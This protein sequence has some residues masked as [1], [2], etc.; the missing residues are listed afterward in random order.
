MKIAILIEGKTERAFLPFLRSFLER[1]L[2]GR[3]P[4][5]DPVPY[6]GRIPKSDKLKREVKR[7]LND[8]R[9]PADAVVALTDVYTRTQP[10]EFEDAEDAKRKMRE[11]VGEENRFY[12]HAAQFEFEAWLLPYW[13]VLQRLAGHNASAPG[14]DPERINH[15]NPPSKRIGD[16]FRRGS[17]GRAYVKEMEAIRVLREA[18]PSI[19]IAQC[20]ELKALVNTILALCGG[21][22]IS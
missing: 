17:K 9:R 12:P 7:L 4:N 18:D 22:S 14:P 20:A 1:P 21:S 16:L 19:A 8:R 5:L 6:D 2:A 11:W 10:P 13:Q 3:M 15:I